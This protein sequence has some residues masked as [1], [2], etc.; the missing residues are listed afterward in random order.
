VTPTSVS[1]C[2]VH[3]HLDH[4]SLHGPTPVVPC[5]VVVQVLPDPLDSI[6][7]GAVRRQEVELQ[8]LRRG[9]LHRQLHLMAVVDA[10]VV[11]NDMDPFG[12]GVSLRD[13]LVEKIQ[14]QQAVLPLAFDISEPPRLGVPRAREV[15][16][17]VAP[18]GQDL[19]LL[20][21]PHPVQSDLGIEVDVDLVEVEHDFVGREI[22]DQPLNLPQA[23][24]SMPL[25]PGALDNRF[26]PLQPDPQLAQKP[27]HGGD[28]DHDIGPLGKYQDQQFLSPRGAPV[29]ELL[30][31]LIDKA[32]QSEFIGRGDLA[33][34]VV[35]ASVGESHQAML[36]E[37]I[38]DSVHL[39]FRAEAALSDPGGSC[40]LNEGKD[41]LATT[42]HSGVLRA[43][44]QSAKLLPLTIRE[45]L[46]SVDD[47]HL[48]QGG[49]PSTGVLDDT[50]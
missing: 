38:G 41:N 7:V 28:A 14:E 8:P 45:P 29:A 18:R 47:F 24:R 12:V 5:N 20:P 46:P 30:G 35:F 3:P 50:T 49:T 4:E 39:R 1:A 17:L 27:T 13:Q 48:N 11:E 37:A 40:T 26:G 31:R 2:Q 22:L 9:R 19:L 33:I 15:A 34:A 25:L 43:L 10:I 6:V 42:S 21:T 36:D 32:E 16:L 44:R 23:T